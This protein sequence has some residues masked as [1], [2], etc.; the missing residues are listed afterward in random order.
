[1]ERQPKIFLSYPTSASG[2]ADLLKREIERVI[3]KSFI[4]DDYQLQDFEIVLNRV[5]ESITDCDYFIGIW[6]HEELSRDGA[7]ISPWMPFE[8][9][10]AMQAGKQSI[11]VFS[12]KLP[13]SIWKRITPGI[14]FPSFNDFTFLDKTIPLLIDYCQSHWLR[15][16]TRLPV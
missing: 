1:M 4:L 13:E 16:P 15:V 12:D 9:G 8:Y 11:I 6:Q 5:I 2:H 10:V 14:S 3:P 7:A